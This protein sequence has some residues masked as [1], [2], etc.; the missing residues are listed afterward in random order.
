[1]GT[2]RTISAGQSGTLVHPLLTVESGVS[3]RAVTQIAA[4][5]ISL[6][7]LPSLKARHVC[8]G[9]EA[10]LAVCALEPWQT[11]ARVAV[12]QLLKQTRILAD[13]LY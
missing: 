8:A 7:A 3:F 12:I 11:R 2:G 6:V 10:V 4:S 5:V 1:M 13:P 9:Q